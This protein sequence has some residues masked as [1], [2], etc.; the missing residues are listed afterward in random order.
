VDLSIEPD[1]DRL[2]VKLQSE[3]WEVNIYASPDELLRLREIRT[4]DWNERRSI[5]AGESAGARAFWANTGDTAAL[6]IGHDDETW[7]IS[8]TLP[9]DVV[10]EIARQAAAQA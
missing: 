10:E 2:A 8:V 1:N 3:E 6:M 7:A 5:E 4:A 9:L